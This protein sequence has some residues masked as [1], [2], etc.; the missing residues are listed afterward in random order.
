ME[1]MRAGREGGEGRRR[2][3]EVEGNRWDEGAKKEEEA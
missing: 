2:S 3:R 1:K